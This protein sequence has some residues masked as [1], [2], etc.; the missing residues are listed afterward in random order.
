MSFNNQRLVLHCD[1]DSFFAAIE[2]R[3]RPQLKNLPVAV[4]GRATDRGVI[5][6]CNYI[7][8]KF[9][10]R[11]AMS[12]AMAE[13]LCPNLIVL[14]PRFSLYRQVSEEMH[15][16][17]SNYSRCIE[18]IA[19]DEAYLE[20]DSDDWNICAEI[21]KDIQ[22]QIESILAITVSAGLSRNKFLA[23]L[24]SEWNKPAGFKIIRDEDVAQVMS[25][26]AVG[27]I[28]SVGG[29]TKEKL[30]KLGIVTCRD[31]QQQS[32]DFLTQHFGVHGQLLFDRCR[33]RDLRTVKN[34]WIRKSISVERTFSNDLVRDDEISAALNS[35]VGLLDERWLRLKSGY[36]AK[37][38]FVKIK[39]SDFSL[40]TRESAFS[41]YIH[42]GEHFSPQQQ[43]QLTST[44]KT[45]LTSAL[46][47]KKASIRLLGLGFSVHQGDQKQMNQTDLFM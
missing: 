38:L 36:L 43:L 44:A 24:A 9:G 14:A 42:S 8:R 26:L 21:A 1:A 25:Q 28:P 11:S 18:P 47:V 32:L 20:L 23:K 13:K 22:R 17:F 2:L 3:D 30:A 35:L 5:A 12:T 40:T 19:L 31:L 27:K 10:V 4:G 33:G 45:L 37:S 46:S 6:T 34:T 15:G 39:Y 7:A 41:G 16:I 29:K